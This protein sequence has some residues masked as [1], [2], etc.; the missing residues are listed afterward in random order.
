MALPEYLVSAVARGGPVVL[1][2]FVALRFGPDA[3][4]RLVA[5]VA[6]VVTK[7][8]ERGDR[9][10]KV[11]RILRG[12]DDDDD[13]PAVPVQQPH[14]SS[15]ATTRRHQKPVLKP[16]FRCMATSRLLASRHA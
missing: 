2:A 5:G 1:L 11:L 8:T 15:T 9:C 13:A 7:N 3:V 16:L 10:L 14:T 4:V 6:A 12:K